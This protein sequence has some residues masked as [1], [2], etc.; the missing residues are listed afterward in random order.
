MKDSVPGQ[1]YVGNEAPQ[2]Q[3]N[4]A[5]GS[6][7]QI[8]ARGGGWTDQYGRCI[9]TLRLQYDLR[10]QEAIGF[11]EFDFDLA[12]VPLDVVIG[13]I[14]VDHDGHRIRIIFV[15][16]FQITGILVLFF[17]RILSRTLRRI[18]DRNK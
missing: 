3:L 5:Y 16:R 14:K 17:F 2:D 18:V 4:P 15:R 6:L 13:R 8:Q 1:S 7:I 11:V 12:D 10:S 9:T